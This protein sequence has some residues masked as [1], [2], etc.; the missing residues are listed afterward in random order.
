[1]SWPLIALGGAQMASSLYGGYDSSKAAKKAGKSASRLIM[2]ETRE[3]MRRTRAQQ[4][5]Q[6]GSTVASIGGSGAMMSGSPQAYLT[7]MQA[8]NRLEM[9]WMERAGK[10]RAKHARRTGG[11]VAD[12]QMMEGVTSSMNTLTNMYTSGLFNSY[13]GMDF[14]SQTPDL[15]GTGT[16]YSP[17]GDLGALDGV[18]A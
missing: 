11:Q 7:A 5:L 17:Y 16:S 8:E 13:G 4:N 10:M 6:E 3:A 15:F 9:D 2:E 14:Q 12:M 18:Q 1:M